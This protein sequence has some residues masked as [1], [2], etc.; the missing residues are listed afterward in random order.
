MIF[1]AGFGTRMGALTKDV[2][3]PMVP[4]AGRPMID[5]TIDLVKGAGTKRIVA[6]THYL[7]EKIEP[8][9]SAQGIQICTEHP[10]I[11]DTGGGLKAA[12]PQLGGDVVITI[13]PDAAWLGPNPIKLLID[14]WDPSMQALLM[15]VPLP[16]AE[17]A[18]QTGDFSLEYGE[19]KRKGD[20]IYTGA[21]IIR[22]AD[23]NRIDDRVFSLNRYWDLLADE[24]PLSG[25]AYDG[26]W[27]D[28]GTPDGLNRAERLIA[29]V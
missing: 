24:G 12:L 14:A 25:I 15:L 1:A 7:P 9:L 4:L 5:H 21:Q 20:Y 18:R 22:T 10:D 3:K 11:L 19:I 6:N 16:N 28:I 2:P 29:H 23:L 17:T 26:R 8:Y 27:C 13:N